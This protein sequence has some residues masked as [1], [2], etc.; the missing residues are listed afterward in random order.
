[1]KDD[2]ADCYE[3]HFENTDEKLLK[4]DYLLQRNAHNFKLIEKPSVNIR[5]Y[6]FINKKTCCKITHT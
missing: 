6:R 2:K 5:S 1:M 3:I 4:D